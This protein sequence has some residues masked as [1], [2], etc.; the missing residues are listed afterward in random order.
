MPPDS[1]ISLFLLM[2]VLQRHV[3]PLVA[4]IPKKPAVF[5]VF[6]NVHYVYCLSQVWFPWHARLQQTAFD[7]YKMHCSPGYAR[8]WLQIQLDCSDWLYVWYIC[9]M[10][11]SNK[12]W[13]MAGLMEDLHWVG[14]Q[15]KLDMRYVAGRCRSYPAAL[16]FEGW[17]EVVWASPILGWPRLP[18]ATSVRQFSILDTWHAGG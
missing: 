6:C 9:H 15:P 13:C 17:W 12:L 1:V 10:M 18:W 4:G 5:Q 14:L 16:T 3:A 2:L 7:K 11:K 8:V